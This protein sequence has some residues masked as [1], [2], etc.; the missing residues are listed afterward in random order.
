MIGEI[1]QTEVSAINC[2]KISQIVLLIV[3][4]FRRSQLIKIYQPQRTGRSCQSEEMET[5]IGRIWQRLLAEFVHHS[6]FSPVKS[7][8]A[9]VDEQRRATAMIGS[10]KDGGLVGILPDVVKLM[11]EEG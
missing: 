5:A 7:E 11:A 9:N 6:R 1:M 3:S 2:K 8:L 4:F 10:G